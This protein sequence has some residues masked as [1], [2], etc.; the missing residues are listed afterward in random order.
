ML[1]GPRSMVPGDLPDIDEH[2]ARGQRGDRRLYMQLLVFG[3]CTAPEAMVMAVGESGMEA[4]VY[5]D[6]HDPFGLGLL[7]ISEDPNFVTT[8]RDLLRGEVFSAAVLKPH[9]TMFGRTYALG[10]EDDL[11][12]TL[13]H[14]PRRHALDPEWPWAIWYPLRRRGAFAQ[15]EDAERQ[16]ILREHGAIGMRFGRGGLARDI[17]LACHGLDAQDNDF[18]IGL[19]G[20]QL[21]P[22]SKLVETMRQTQQTSTYLERLGPFFVGRVAWQ[23]PAG[24]P[25]GG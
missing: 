23:S 22:L 11:D 18:V 15:L 21:G 25:E 8:L 4:V 16:A 17:R 1:Y 9:L 2:G 6:L 12:E 3:R 13:L 7:V 24:V 19:T 20:R 14:R 5:E 10:Y